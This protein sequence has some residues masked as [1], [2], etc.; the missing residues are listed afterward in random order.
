MPPLQSLSV[1]NAVH[2]TGDVGNNSD[3]DGQQQQ[4]HPLTQTRQGSTNTEKILLIIFGSCSIFFYAG[5]F[6]GWGPMQLLLESNGNFQ[7]KCS[8]E[9]WE[10]LDDDESSEGVEAEPTNQ[11]CPE[12]TSAL[13]TARTVGVLTVLT[14]PLWAYISDKYGGQTLTYNLFITMILGLVLLIIAFEF[15]GSQWEGFL[16]YTSF[17]LIGIG[18]TCGGLLTVVTALLF[19]APK[20]EDHQRE[21]NDDENGPADNRNSPHNNNYSNNQENTSS[22]SKTQSRVISLMNSLYDAAAMTYLTL[23][24]LVQLTSNI[25]GIL[26]GYLCFAVLFLGGYVY[27]FRRVAHAQRNQVQDAKEDDSND[28]SSGNLVKKDEEKDAKEDFPINNKGRSSAATALTTTDESTSRLHNDDENAR[29]SNH[30]QTLDLTTTGAPTQ[31]ALPN[32]QDLPNDNIQPNVVSSPYVTIAKRSFVGQLWSQAFVLLVGFFTIHFMSNIWTLTTIR[33]FL[34]YLGDDEKGNRYLAIFTLLT[35]VSLLALPFVDVAIH[36]FGYSVALQA[37]NTLDMIQC[38]IKVIP[39]A[40]LNVQIVGFVVFSFFRCF[41]FCVTL[42]AMPTFIAGN[43]VARATSVIYVVSSLAT[44]VHI[45]LVNLAVNSQGGNFFIPNL[46]FLFLT[47]PGAVFA[48][49]LG[50]AICRDWES[51]IEMT[52]P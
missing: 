30:T 4:S 19:D 37:V 43:T 34:R 27:F 3:G 18:G 9:S 41:L 13:L 5:A 8:D 20:Q 11:V 10:S 52:T 36:R 40:N 47:I 32:L 17:I 24:G 2:T 33:D 26:I 23:W 39:G 21:A 29:A 14:A 28:T 51:K 35:P 7:S 22:G 44:L 15:P 6:Y 31:D 25:V 46:F 1:D 45:P 12:Q 50:K 48:W 42:S 16:L 49:L 38:L